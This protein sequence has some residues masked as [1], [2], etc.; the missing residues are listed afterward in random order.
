MADHNERGRK[1]EEEACFYLMEQ[2]YRIIQRNWKIHKLE[3]DLIAESSSELLFVEVKTRKKGSL[4]SPLDAVT[5]QKQLNIL[6]AA[7]AYYKINQP[8]VDY[9]FDI[10]TV[11]EDEEGNK[12]IEHL[13]DAFRPSVGSIRR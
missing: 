2:G 13:P 3:V 5:P 7:H 6:K 9:R 10:I 8:R 4:V 12:E 11:I 1:G